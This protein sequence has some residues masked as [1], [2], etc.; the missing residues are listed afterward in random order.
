MKWCANE[1]GVPMVDGHAETQRVGASAEGT[2][3]LRAPGRGCGVWLGYVEA[4]VR[5]ELLW[6]ERTE[7]QLRGRRRIRV[8]V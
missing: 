1:A 7:G 6:G 3:K 4:E 5:Q 2:R 8:R